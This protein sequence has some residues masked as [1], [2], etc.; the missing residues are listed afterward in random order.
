MILPRLLSFLESKIIRQNLPSQNLLLGSLP[1]TIRL[2]QSLLL[3]TLNLL[4]LSTLAK[5]RLISTL[6]NLN[7]PTTLM[8][9]MMRKNPKSNRRLYFPQTPFLPFQ[10]TS[11]AFTQCQYLPI[12]PSSPPPVPGGPSM[13]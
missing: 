2:H 4:K 6:P 5:Q 3:P 1:L 11:L 7:R 13:T 9:A 8:L 12:S 10:S